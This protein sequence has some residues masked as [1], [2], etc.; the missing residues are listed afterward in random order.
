M[1]IFR[2]APSNRHPFVPPVEPAMSAEARLQ[3]SHLVFD[4]DF[5]FCFSGGPYKGG[6]ALE[7]PVLPKV[8]SGI[9]RIKMRQT[10]FDLTSQHT[11]SRSTQRR[12]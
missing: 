9:A 6:T 3:V 4:R 8:S 5:F 1:L 10:P 12:T 11:S 7:P 2:E